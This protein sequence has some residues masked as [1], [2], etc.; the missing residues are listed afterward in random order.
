MARDAGYN[1]ALFKS[2][3]EA[4]ATEST[5]GICAI[6]SDFDLGNGPNGIQ[7]A[8]MLRAERK[9]SPPVLIVTATRHA[10]VEAAVRAAGFEMSPKPASPSF[11]RRWL[12][13]N[14]ACAGAAPLL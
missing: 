6:I 5:S 8:Q 13:Q 10:Y 14:T 4:R 2:F 1:A 12:A 3:A 7:A 9:S 11:L